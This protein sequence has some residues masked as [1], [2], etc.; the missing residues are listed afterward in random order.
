MNGN[1]QVAMFSSFNNDKGNAY[2]EI[3]KRVKWVTMALAVK[4]LHEL[5]TFQPPPQCNRISLYHQF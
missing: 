4:V 5:S 1:V 2:M 3:L